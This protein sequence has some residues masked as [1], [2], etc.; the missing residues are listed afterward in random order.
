[1]SSFLLDTNNAESVPVEEGLPKFK[2]AK[3]KDFEPDDLKKVRKEIVCAREPAGEVSGDKEPKGLDLLQQQMPPEPEPASK[4]FDKTDPKIENDLC[5][6]TYV[7]RPDSI[8]IMLVE[9]IRLFEEILLKCQ[10]NIERLVDVREGNRCLCKMEGLFYRAQILELDSERLISKIRYTDFGKVESKPVYSLFKL[11]DSLWSRA[12]A[13]L[14]RISEIQSIT[15]QEWSREEVDLL[16]GVK[17]EQRFKYTL[18]G[19]D[20]VLLT[21]MKGNSV[22]EA[23]VEAGLAK[24]ADPKL[25][26][27]ATEEKGKRYFVSQFFPNYVFSC[28][29]YNLFNETNLT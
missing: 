18:T 3:F 7:E 9:D 8:Y 29:R 6:V 12:L 17:I 25:V 19:K 27:E 28:R 10:N 13:R 1:M 5:I 15:G 21:D 22:G 24:Y 26:Q 23:L 16:F 2:V 11:E 4:G 14:V 20:E